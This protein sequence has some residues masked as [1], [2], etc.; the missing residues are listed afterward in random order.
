LDGALTPRS[1]TASVT[2]LA[3]EKPV[4]QGGRRGLSVRF[5]LHTRGLRAARL[6]LETTLHE[7]LKGPLTSRMATFAD[8]QGALELFETFVPKDDGPTDDD[9]TSFIPFEAIDPGHEGTVKCFARVR[10][11]EERRGEL[12]KEE[13]AFEL[14]AG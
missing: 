5:R 1:G 7:Q 9:H 12:A 10:V 2:D 14:V 13:V 4:E 3:V 11:L 8:G 6:V